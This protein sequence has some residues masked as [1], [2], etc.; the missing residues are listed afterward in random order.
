[1]LVAARN[2]SRQFIRKRKD[3]NVFFP[4]KELD[5]TLDTGE[6]VV[7]DGASGSGKST[8]M[9]M[10]SGILRPTTGEVMY[11]IGSDSDN[12]NLYKLND[13]Q[14]A[15]FRNKYIGVA[16]QGQT[17]V[18]SLTVRENILLPYTL[19]GKEYKKLKEAEQA[20]TY[21]D[22]LME[23][24]GITEL[25]DIMTSELSGGEMR[26]MAIARALIKRPEVIMADEPTADLDEENTHIVMELLK[27]QS[28]SGK[29]VL[30]VTHDRDVIPYADTVYHMKDGVLAIS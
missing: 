22:E 2:I 14:L 28:M 10:L 9:S 21:A 1:M 7:I 30:I 4:V 19:Y 29:A 26:R 25:G 5:F 27:A 15:E 3:S 18:S 8:L 16:P 24:L 6:L 13:R 17:A 20:E 23:K 11:C 12:T